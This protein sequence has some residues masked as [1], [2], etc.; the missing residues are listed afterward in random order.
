[1]R[2]LTPPTPPAWF[3]HQEFA[4]EHRGF[5]IAQTDR[6]YLLWSVKT[7]DFGDPPTNLRGFFTSPGKA[8]QFIDDFLKEE[9]RKQALADAEAS[10]AG[11]KA[12][13]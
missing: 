9:E 11:S 4:F 6:D 13:P 10:E 12:K 3:G 1:M 7:K 2:T 8:K 5:V